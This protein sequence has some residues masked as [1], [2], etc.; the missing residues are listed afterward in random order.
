MN[1]KINNNY[2]TDVN[3]VNEFP[4]LENAPPANVSFVYAAY[5]KPGQHKFLIYCPKT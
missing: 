4:D 3:V 1:D 5:V 2:L